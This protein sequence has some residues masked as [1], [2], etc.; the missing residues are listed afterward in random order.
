[1]I[2]FHV[3]LQTFRLRPAQ[4]F[5]SSFKRKCD[6]HQ[7]EVRWIRSDNVRTPGDGWGTR[8]AGDRRRPVAKLVAGS[9]NG[10]ERRPRRTTA[11]EPDHQPSKKQNFTFLN[12]RPEYVRNDWNIA[13]FILLEWMDL[14]LI[15]AVRPTNHIPPSGGCNKR[16]NWKW[17]WMMTLLGTPVNTR[18]WLHYF[19]RKIEK[20]FFKKKSVT[21]GGRDLQLST[22]FGGRAGGNER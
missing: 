20:Y 21:S 5:K 9:S 6:L 3:I 13:L 12:C 22:T 18:K 19:F 8:Y 10:T 16:P 1:M 15:C 7:S 4:L 11:N 17:F 2:S 14:P